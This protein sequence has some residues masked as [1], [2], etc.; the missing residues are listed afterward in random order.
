LNRFNDDSDNDNDDGDDEDEDAELWDKILDDY[1][2][3]VEDLA[4]LMT[5]ES[6]FTGLPNLLFILL[7]HSG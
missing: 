4:E 2:Q 3:E 1:E 6:Y 5:G 7:A